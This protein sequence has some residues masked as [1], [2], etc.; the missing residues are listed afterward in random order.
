MYCRNYTG[1]VSHVLC[2][3]VYCTLSVSGRVH[4]QRFHCTTYST[5][6]L[7]MYVRTYSI[8]VGVAIAECTIGGSTALRIL[9]IL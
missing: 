4:Y 8:R 9:H 7:I 6:T 3:E 5:D 2:R 1:T